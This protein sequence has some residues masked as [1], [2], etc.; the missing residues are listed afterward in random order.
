[1][2]AQDA[3]ACTRTGARYAREG[4]P[5]G[6]LAADAA[7]GEVQAHFGHYAHVG[8]ERADLLDRIG[9]DQ[10]I[11]YPPRVQ[12][13]TDEDAGR[14]RENRLGC[15]VVVGTYGGAQHRG[16]KAFELAGGPGSVGREA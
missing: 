13:H 6:R 16:A 15:A 2:E 7:R 10:P 8:H 9:C 3:P 14:A 1:M 5:L 4:L 11:V 12:A